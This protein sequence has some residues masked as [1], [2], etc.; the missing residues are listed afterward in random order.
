MKTTANYLLGLVLVGSLVCAPYHN[1]FAGDDEDKAFRYFKYGENY[2]KIG[3]YDTALDWYQKAAD[4]RDSDGTLSIT[5]ET[6]IKSEKYVPYGRTVKKVVTYETINADYY[7]IRRILEIR[8]IQER[9]Y[10][11]PV[12]VPVPVAAPV[13]PPLGLS[14][15]D[16]NIPVT[17][18]SNRDAIA[19]VIGNRD[20]QEKGVPSVDFALNDAT[21][22]KQYL[23]NVLGYQE[24]NIIFEQNASKGKFESI[25]GIKGNHQGRLYNYLKSGKSDIFIYYSGH[26]AP[27]MNTHEGYFVP[28]DADPQSIGLTGYPLSVLYENIAKTV[29]DMKTPNVFIVIEACFSGATEK[30]LLLKNMSPIAIEASTPLLTMHNAAVMTSSSG[31]EVSSWYPEKSHGMFTYFFLSALRDAALKGKGTVSAGQIFK[32]VADETEG[33]PYFARR[34]Y[35][36]IQKPQMMGD[37]ERTFMQFQQATP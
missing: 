24:G 4:L 32:T 37:A 19:V 25:F 11:A 27:D 5:D 9:Q 13:V 22:M 29:N 23:I 35:G 6:R 20:Y 3:S 15:V 8:R 34:N 26:G 18:L 31:S 28:S 14:D 17:H 1:A 33:L 21:T 10:A 16:L 12:Q 36:R 2:F 30:G 7:P